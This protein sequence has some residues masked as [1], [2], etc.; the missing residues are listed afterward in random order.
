MYGLV[1]SHKAAVRGRLATHGQHEET[2][3]HQG[4]KGDAI[5]GDHAAKIG[6]QG[7][8]RVLRAVSTAAST[9][10]ATKWCDISA[11]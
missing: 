5:H 2:R 10:C 7:A 3:D 4:D 1:V 9:T 11:A 6:C 8:P